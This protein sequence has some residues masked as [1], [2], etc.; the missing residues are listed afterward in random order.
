M[1]RNNSKNFL[2]WIQK[3][4]E[5]FALAKV[6]L[7]EKGFY[8]HICLLC[9]QA[10][11]KYLKSFIIK[12]RKEPPLIHN[13]NTL[14]EICKEYNID[15]SYYETELRILTQYY[16]PAKYPIPSIVIFTKEEAKKAIEFAGKIIEK[17]QEEM[18]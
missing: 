10:V 11:E 18:E 1:K 8:A 12:N 5:D 13:L 4:N 6:I 14:A 15:L 16:I 7:K 2:S 9:Q 17:I 3:A